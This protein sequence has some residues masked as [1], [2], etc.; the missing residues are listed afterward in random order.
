MMDEVGAENCEVLDEEAKI[1]LGEEKLSGIKIQI[2]AA[3]IEVV[4]EIY[5][6]PSR[7]SVTKFLIFQDTPD[8]S[9]NRSKEYAQA[10]KEME[11][12]FKVEKE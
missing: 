8:E 4:M 5:Q 2:S 9:G 12:S 11:T 6:V 1:T 3:G 7:D 10:I